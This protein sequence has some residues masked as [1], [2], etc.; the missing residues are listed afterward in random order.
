M[1]EESPDSDSKQASQAA[2]D[3]A[4]AQYDSPQKIEAL[5]KLRV[6]AGLDDPWNG[7]NYGLALL[8]EGDPKAVEVL[9]RVGDQG[10]FCAHAT[11][12]MALTFGHYLPKDKAKGA[13]LLRKATERDHVY[14]KA[15]LIW[16]HSNI[17]RLKR[18]MLT[19]RIIL[20][21]LKI[22]I[23]S[24]DNDERLYCRPYYPKS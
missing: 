23:W 6:L 4:W 15:V 7:Y 8:Y 14:A 3:E 21:I 12:G 20:K 17:G 16:H 1:A 9:E 10:M 24:E 19:S 5:E 22:S 11:I 13:Y 18:Y 2:L